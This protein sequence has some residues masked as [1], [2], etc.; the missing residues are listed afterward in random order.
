MRP[1]VGKKIK[2]GPGLKIDPVKKQTIRC[3]PNPFH[4]KITIDNSQGISSVKIFDISGKLVA[5]SDNCEVQTLAV[6][7]GIYNVQVL[8]R[9]GEMYHQKMVKLQ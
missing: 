7:P 8:S 4:D 9:N 1:Y 3:Y 6:A 2:L 5:E